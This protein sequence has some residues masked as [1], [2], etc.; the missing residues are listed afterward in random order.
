MG[1]VQVKQI[2]SESAAVSGA[3]NPLL[4]IKVSNSRRVL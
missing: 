3:L 1:Q 4:R 2:Q